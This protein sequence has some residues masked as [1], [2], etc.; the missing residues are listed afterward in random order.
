MFQVPHNSILKKA[1]PF[2][3]SV[4]CIQVVDRPPVIIIADQ[5]E[6]MTLHDT[7]YDGDVLALTETM[8]QLQ[9]FLEMENAS[10]V[11]KVHQVKEK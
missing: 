7:L 2:K 8:V 3:L 10:V 6:T 9:D 1:F 11:E 5:I 4:C